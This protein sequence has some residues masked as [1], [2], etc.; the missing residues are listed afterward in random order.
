MPEAEALEGHFLLLCFS[1]KWKIRCVLGK[2][3]QFFGEVILSKE[4][5]SYN[6]VKY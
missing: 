2:C 4:A 1:C 5:K 3:F 6:G